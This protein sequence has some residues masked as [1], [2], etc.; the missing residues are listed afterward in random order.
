[1]FPSISVSDTG[2]SV[3]DAHIYWAEIREIVA[4][5]VDLL[6]VD[7]VRFAFR[8][9]SGADDA[10]F[11]VSEEQ[12]G[13]ADLVAEL[14]SRFPSVRGWRARVIKPAFAANRIQL[15]LVD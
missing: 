5:K 4:F 9:Q 15:Y 14:E 11:E 1:M 12:P 3:E 8:F 7:D 2:F 6:T 10:W 13:F